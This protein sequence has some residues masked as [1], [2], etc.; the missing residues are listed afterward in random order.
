MPN[1]A[2]GLTTRLCTGVETTYGTVQTP[3][4]FME[5]N[6]EGLERKNEIMRSNA[7]GSGSLHLRKGSRSVVSGRW[8]EGPID[9]DVVTNGMGRLFANLMGGTPTIVQQGAGPAWLQTFTLGSQLGKSLTIQK[10]LRDESDTVVAKFTFEGSKIIAAE[11]KIDKKGKLTLSLTVNSEDVN[12]STAAATPSLG[13]TKVFHFRQGYLT[14]AGVAAAQVQLA[15]V[16]V[17][18]KSDT[19]RFHLGNAGVKAEPV[20][21][22]FPDIG[23]AI[24]AEFA[25]STYY[26]LFAADT[27]ASM[28]LQFLGDVIPTTIINESLTIT[29]PE[30]RLTGET[31]KVSGPGLILATHP[32]E[33]QWDGAAA[34]M[35][36]SYM[37]TDLAI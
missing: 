13:A 10:Q 7:L 16:K 19:D 6:S 35:T 30:I 22:D 34:D 37:S 4:R 26:D 28:T 3:D 20:V 31:P 21:N 25:A 15:S 23:G 33:A 36:L 17:D 2:V 18:R 1:P 32:F 5:F 12:T 24:T 11:F 9:M 29:I 14:I 8:G 27:A